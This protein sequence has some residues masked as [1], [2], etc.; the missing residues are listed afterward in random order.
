MFYDSKVVKTPPP[1]PPFM[2]HSPGRDESSGDISSF[3]FDGQELSS[4]GS[5]AERKI[6]NAT[7]IK[8]L[9]STFTR[10]KPI[11]NED[12]TKKAMTDLVKKTGAEK[13]TIQAN[14]GTIRIPK[15]N[16]E[17]ECLLHDIGVGRVSLQGISG[18]NIS[19]LAAKIAVAA[20]LDPKFIFKLLIS[21]IEGERRNITNQSA[22]QFD[23]N[24]KKPPSIDIKKQGFEVSSAP[25]VSSTPHNME[26]KTSVH[27]LQGKMPNSNKGNISQGRPLQLDG[28]HYQTAKGSGLKQ[29]QSSLKLSDLDKTLTPLKS[30]KDGEKHLTSF[31][32]QSLSSSSVTSH[33]I[34][35]LRRSGSPLHVSSEQIV[36]QEQYKSPVGLVTSAPQGSR[37]ARPISSVMPLVALPESRPLYRDSGVQCLTRQDQIQSVERGA[38]F[39]RPVSTPRS[40][41]VSTADAAIQCEVV[42]SADGIGSETDLVTPSHHSLKKMSGVSLSATSKSSIKMRTNQFLSSTAILG[43]EPDDEPTKA[44]T[45]SPVVA[46]VGTSL[47]EQDMSNWKPLKAASSSK[48]TGTTVFLRTH[49]QHE[50]P[51]MDRF[52]DTTV[53]FHKD[54]IHDILPR[55]SDIKVRESNAM[56]YPLMATNQTVIGRPSIVPSTQLQPLHHPTALKAPRPAENKNDAVSPVSSKVIPMPTIQ[57][58]VPNEICFSGVQCI[59]VAINECLPIHNPSSRWIQCMLELVFYSVNG[60]QVRLLLF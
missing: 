28:A 32:I 12:L 24:T 58:I 53:Q 25:T 46:E 59:G 10:S 11:L 8:E 4:H 5:N 40:R 55:L 41:C 18:V 49:A 23:A 34:G 19:N 54:Q 16:D 37:P 36:S 20:N 42:G 26:Y 22:P 56:F 45:L 17:A 47:L 29:D 51:T 44:I 31:S 60:S 13:D 43:A 48:Q 33:P 7:S 6:D 1:L 30:T 50:N 21:S 38:R 9:S 15:T 14:D 35:K 27:T 2:L 3:T 52:S 57:I 39:D